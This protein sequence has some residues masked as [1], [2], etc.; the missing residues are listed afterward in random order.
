MSDTI[1]DPPP[2]PTVPDVAL[3]P[4]APPLGR[5]RLWIAGTV[6]ALAVLIAGLGLLFYFRVWRY[7]ATARRH[8][9]SNANVA[10]RLELADLVLFGPVRKHLLPLALPEKDASGAAKP[11]KSFGERLKE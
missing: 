1:V 8:I 5:A 6:T 11:G 7:E 4:P 3:A 9:P 2:P 10:I